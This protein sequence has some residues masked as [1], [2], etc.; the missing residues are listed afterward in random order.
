MTGRLKSIVVTLVALLVLA[1]AYLAAAHFSGG[2]FPTMGLPLGGP[3]AEMRRK[4]LSFWEDIQ[5]KD[6]D[7]ATRYH[8]PEARRTVDIRY[9]I[10]RTFGVKP[11]L[12]DIKEYEVMWVD[13]DSTGLRARV[14]TRTKAQILNREKIETAE[15]MFYFTRDDLDSPWYMNFETSLRNPEKG[16][17]DLKR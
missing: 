9:L 7:G 12:I 4:V 3:E 16:G 2:A 15:V 11:E 13:M 10:E 8:A 5:F 17:Q 14:R 1:G 6:F